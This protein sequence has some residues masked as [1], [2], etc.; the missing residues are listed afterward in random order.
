MKIRSARKMDRWR[1]DCVW[2]VCPLKQLIGK[3]ISLGIITI[4]KL[5]AT[6]DAQT[7]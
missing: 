3:I 6:K 2:L 5:P 7:F 4:I 1:A